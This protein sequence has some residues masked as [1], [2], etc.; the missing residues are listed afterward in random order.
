[1]AEEAT[2]GVNKMGAERNPFW[3]MFHYC[4]EEMISENYHPDVLKCP[5]KKT[6][7]S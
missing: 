7:S 5:F 6:K 1:M 4:S 2:F 3:R